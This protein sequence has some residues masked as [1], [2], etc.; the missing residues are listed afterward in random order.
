[1]VYLDSYMKYFW[2]RNWRKN[3]D[4]WFQPEWELFKNETYTVAAILICINWIY[5]CFIWQQSTHSYKNLRIT[6]VRFN[7]HSAC[8]HN[9]TE[10]R[11]ARH[12]ANP[13]ANL[14]N[15]PLRCNFSLNIITNILTLINELD[16]LTPCCCWWWECSRFKSWIHIKLTV[17][18]IWT[19]FSIVHFIPQW[20]QTVID[21]WSKCKL[22]NSIHTSIPIM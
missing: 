6:R 13:E 21:W 8:A 18:S 10:V 12:L 20:L 16:I 17:N 3:S 15:V 9:M 7:L 4:R 14:G 5:F 22:N 11:R 2:N 19:K 1:M